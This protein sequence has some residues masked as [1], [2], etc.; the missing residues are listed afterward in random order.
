MVIDFKICFVCY[1][2]GNKIRTNGSTTASIAKLPK[3]IQE[4]L[5]SFLTNFNNIGELKLLLGNTITA[6]KEQE[7]DDT[8]RSTTLIT[9]N[10]QKLT[11]NSYNISEQ[12]LCDSHI[13]LATCTDVGRMVFQTLLYRQPEELERY[14]ALCLVTPPPVALSRKIKHIIDKIKRIQESLTETTKKY[15]LTH[16]GNTTTITTTSATAATT[17]KINTHN[18]HTEDINGLLTDIENQYILVQR[19]ISFLYTE[20]NNLIAIQSKQCL[21]Y[22]SPLPLVV[23]RDDL[24]DSLQDLNLGTPRT[25]ILQKEHDL[26]VNTRLGGSLASPVQFSSYRTD[27]KPIVSTRK[28]CISPRKVSCT[29][30]DKLRNTV[31]DCKRPTYSLELYEQFIEGQDEEEGQQTEHMLY[32]HNSIAYRHCSAKYRH[33]RGSH[34]KSP[35]YEQQVQLASSTAVERYHSSL[36]VSTRLS[37]FSLDTPQKT[38]IP[39][40]TSPYANTD[41]ASASWRLC[42]NSPGDWRHVQPYLPIATS[43]STTSGTTTASNTTTATRIEKAEVSPLIGVL[44]HID[45][46]VQ[47]Q[48]KTPPPP[49]LPVPP[50]I[51]INPT[52]SAPV[53]G[54]GKGLGAVDSHTA[55]GSASL[56]GTSSSGRSRQREGE[57]EALPPRSRSGSSNSSSADPGGSQ[58]VLSPGM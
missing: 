42:L 43:T 12:L 38:P 28:D 7:I 41:T 53:V 34:R 56:H 18:L 9:K 26:I 14:R 4:L 16:T 27:K 2:L 19:M 51:K 13:A 29:A 47:R 52:T 57:N 46:Y 37:P 30:W 58:E 15:D 40:D 32:K 10:L 36:R 21:P 50:P 31:K 35:S 44:Q 11:R 1:N 23:V 6:G 45:Q 24:A 8:I 48:P 33:L 49:S 17:N 20:I 5:K 25:N 54:E 22:T 3:D 39:R 55:G